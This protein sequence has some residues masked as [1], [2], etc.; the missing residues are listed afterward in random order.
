MS[1]EKTLSPFEVDITYPSAFLWFWPLWACRRGM[2]L[3]DQVL[4]SEDCFLCCDKCG[5]MIEFEGI[6]I[7]GDCKLLKKE[8]SDAE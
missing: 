1:D 4:T 6:T 3:W 5:L 8:K 7:D 2:H